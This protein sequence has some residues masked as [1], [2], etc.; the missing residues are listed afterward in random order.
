MKRSSYRNAPALFGLVGFT[1]WMFGCAHEPPAPWKGRPPAINLG[2]QLELASFKTS[3][4]HTAVL[5]DSAGNAHVVVAAASTREV[6]H[7]TV[8]RDGMVQRELVSADRAPSTISAAFDSA[9]QLHLLMDATHMVREASGWK[10]DA[11]T[12]WDAAG[13]KAQQPRLV[14]YRDG[15]VWAFIVDGREVGASGRWDWYLIGGAFAAIAIPWHSASDKLV[16][17]S[18]SA[19]SAPSWYVIDPQDSLDADNAMFAAD[20]HGN[21]NVVYSATQVA[22]AKLEQPRQALIPLA[23]VA[24]QQA[25]MPAAPLRSTTLYPVSGAPL[26]APQSAQDLNQASVAVDPES[27]LLLF[28]NAHQA[29]TTFSDGAWS[30]PIRLP[31]SKFWEPSLAA[32]GKDAFHLLTVADSQVLYLL[33]AQEDWSAPVELGQARVATTFGAMWDAL[34]IA[35]NGHNR[36]FAVWPTESGIAGR[37]IE[38]TAEIKAGPRA[39]GIDLGHGI[40]LPPSLLDFAHGKATLVEP[41]VFEGADPAL[42]AINHTRVAKQLHDAGQWVSL[43]LLVF[44]DNYGDDVRWYFLGRAAEG[45]ALCDAAETYYAQSRK[46]SELFWLGG[47]RAGLQFPQILDERRAAIQIMRSGGQCVTPPRQP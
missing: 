8:S 38:G 39:D 36:A 3:T 28:V 16:I 21:L 5:L 19:G 44:N 45:L 42:S 22:L 30:R 32:A 20:N 6:Q 17:V 27:G 35:S 23:N 2:P 13:V 18:P 47:V 9:G 26:R 40:V 14:Q 31:L 7:V 29:A 1:L 11:Y 37:W 33:F 34:G 25:P 10:A 24:P 43:A 46:R 15:L 12:P 41:R 4:D